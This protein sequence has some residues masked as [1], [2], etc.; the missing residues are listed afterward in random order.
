MMINLEETV[1]N[2][3]WSGLKSEIFQ[4][5]KDPW[6]QFCFWF[7][8]ENRSA[9]FFADHLQDEVSNFDL[10]IDDEKTKCFIIS[11]EEERDKYLEVIVGKN[12]K[13]KI[14]NVEN[15]GCARKETANN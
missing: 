1:N 9:F 4:V 7:G 13:D 2:L 11:N 5:K 8:N 6:P 14:E 12:I 3:I 10:N 15:F